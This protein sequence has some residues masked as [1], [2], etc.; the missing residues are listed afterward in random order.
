MAYIDINTETSNLPLEVEDV[1][2]YSEKWFFGGQGSPIESDYDFQEQEVPLSREDAKRE[3]WPFLE[4][5][6]IRT[7]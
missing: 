3:Y 2:Q 4:E 5:V 7:L 6:N 1:Q